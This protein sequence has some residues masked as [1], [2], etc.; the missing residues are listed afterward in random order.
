MGYDRDRLTCDVKGCTAQLAI[1]QYFHPEWQCGPGDRSLGDG[2]RTEKPFFSYGERGSRG[3]WKVLC[4]NHNAGDL[5]R[6]PPSTGDEWSAERF[7]AYRDGM[8][9]HD[10]QRAAE[11]SCSHDQGCVCGRR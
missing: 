4:P 5:E 9:E 3:R 11:A 7:R 6:P 8:I 2:W 10:L 1:T